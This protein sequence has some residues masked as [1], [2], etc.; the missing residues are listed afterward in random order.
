MW[1]LTIIVCLVIGLALAE[2]KE[3]IEEDSE[4]FS[5][6]LHDI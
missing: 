1:I 5:K 4:L 3:I 6:L 2:D